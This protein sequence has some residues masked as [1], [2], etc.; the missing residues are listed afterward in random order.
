MQ[1]HKYM[2]AAL[3]VLTSN[4]A[5]ASHDLN[6]IIKKLDVTSFRNSLGPRSL[7]KGTTLPSV[8][9]NKSVDYKDSNMA[10]LTNEENA[11][12]YS[13]KEL[14]KHNENVVVCFY[15]YASPGQGSYRSVELLTL[16]KTDN[17]LYISTNEKQATEE[18]NQ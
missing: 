8:G 9:F 4:S 6:T 12:T 14:K 5:F 2:I 13:I 11:W 7:P 10:G 16:T 18:C 3:C 15:D 1:T 17:G